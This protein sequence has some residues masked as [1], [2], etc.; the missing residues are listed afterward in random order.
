MLNYLNHIIRSKGLNNIA[1]R[2]FMICNR[3]GIGARKSEKAL[4]DILDLTERHNYTPTFVPGL[5][6]SSR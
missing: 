3:F 4:N 2:F 5:I 6:L 1:G